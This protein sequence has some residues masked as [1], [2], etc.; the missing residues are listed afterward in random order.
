MI[1]NTIFSNCSAPQGGAL[2]ISAEGNASVEVK[3]S[4]FADN[5]VHSN[6]HITFEG[7][8]YLSLAPDTQIK[9]GCIIEPETAKKIRS[10]D[11]YEFPSW[12]YKSNITFENSI[13]VGNA[14]AV[15]RAVY[16][17][18][19]YETFRNCSFIDNVAA[20]QGGQIYTEDGSS[21]SDVQNCIFRQRA[22]R[23]LPNQG[24]KATFIHSKSSGALK[25][26]NTT[27]D[28][29]PYETDFL[30]LVRNGRLIDLGNNNLTIFNCPNEIQIN[31]INYTHQVTL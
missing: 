16:I 17:A 30:L 24:T 22:L 3:N 6:D 7:A 12:A 20:F 4:R 21:G 9:S 13:F 15:G 23:Q 2:Y 27:M 29:Q 5:F 1:L 25:L 31:I 14:G 19:G 8:V 10:V 26:Y 18:N 28:S 11:S